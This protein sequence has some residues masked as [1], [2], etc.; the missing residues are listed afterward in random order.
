MQLS[1]KFCT[2][3]SAEIVPTSP[4]TAFKLYLERINDITRDTRITDRW[5]AER[6]LEIVAVVPERCA[7]LC[8]GFATPG[9]WTMF[10]RFGRPLTFLRVT[11]CVE[12]R[13]N[14]EDERCGSPTLER[15]RERT[16]TAEGVETDGS[17]QT[18]HFLCS[19][20]TIYSVNVEK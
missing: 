4:W 5:G 17:E 8:K 12:K 20:F 9:Q 1:C 6:R 14:R 10:A 3:G 2:S 11:W 15:T 19:P 13:K 18:F 7:A 16:S